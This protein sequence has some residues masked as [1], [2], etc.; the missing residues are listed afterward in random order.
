MKKPKFTARSEDYDDAL[1]TH[2][3]GVG[4]ATVE[5][6]TSESERCETLTRERDLWKRR[7]EAAVRRGAQA[8]SDCD[9][10]ATGLHH[11]LDQCGFRKDVVDRAQDFLERAVLLDCPDPKET[12]GEGEA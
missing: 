4:T 11:F 7:Y 2:T 5:V 12:P 9:R 1:G 6:S 10:V 8:L 3:A